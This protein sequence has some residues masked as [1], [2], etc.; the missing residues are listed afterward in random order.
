M[1]KIYQQPLAWVQSVEGESL[2]NG[3]SIVD[4]SGNQKDTL[5]SDNTSGGSAD[6]DGTV[7]GDAKP[8]NPWTAWD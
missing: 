8:C 5:G 2:L 7:W 4:G 3:G 1:K 6:G